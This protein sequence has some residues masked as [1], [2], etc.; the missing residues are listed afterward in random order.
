MNLKELTSLCNDLG[1]NPED[2]NIHPRYDE[3][4]I[5]II[6]FPFNGTAEQLSDRLTELDVDILMSSVKN[7][8][9]EFWT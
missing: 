4:G 3:S 8:Y 5:L 1:I 2:F 9:G 6:S 7:G